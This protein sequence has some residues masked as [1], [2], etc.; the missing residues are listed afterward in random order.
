[1]LFD[2][3]ER[4][5]RVEALHHD[6]EIRDY[7]RFLRKTWEDLGVREPD[8][9]FTRCDSFNSLNHGLLPRLDYAQ[10]GR[11]ALSTVNVY[12]KTYGSQAQ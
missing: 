5:H 11:L 7:Y 8:V 1:M 2:E 12:P 4:G 3:A 9:L 6:D 10:D